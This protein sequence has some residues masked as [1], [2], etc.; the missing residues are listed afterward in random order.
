[1]LVL[2][3][4]IAVPVLLLLIGLWLRFAPTAWSRQDADLPTDSPTTPNE[5]RDHLRRS[6]GKCFITIAVICGIVFAAVY[7]S[8]LYARIT[9]AQRAKFLLLPVALYLMAT[10]MIRRRWFKS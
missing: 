6:F 7:G 10:V 8:G 4:Y 2:I 1:M 3:G 5:R 9:E